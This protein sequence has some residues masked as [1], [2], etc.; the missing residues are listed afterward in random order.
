MTC[1]LYILIF[2]Q[3]YHWRSLWNIPTYSGKLYR[4]MGQF[5]P[6]SWRKFSWSA[7]YSLK[8]WLAVL[9]LIVM[10]SFPILK[11]AYWTNVSLSLTCRKEYDVL[12]SKI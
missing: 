10:V 4:F 8:R 5:T 7:T 2:D 11:S 1:I 3:K 9:G 12:N 6:Y